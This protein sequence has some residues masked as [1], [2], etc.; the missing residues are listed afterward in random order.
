MNELDRF[1]SEKLSTAIENAQDTGRADLAD[2]LQLKAA[3]DAFRQAGVEQF[4]ETMIEIA[5]RTEHA[6]KQIAVERESPHSF[7]HRDANLVGSLVRLRY[8]VRCMTVEAGWTRTPSDGFM[9]LGALAF[10]RITH[11]GIPRANAE[12]ILKNT[13]GE[14]TWAVVRR[15]K[16]DT[17]FELV[18]L[19]EHFLV[20]IDERR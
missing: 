4:F 8:G 7:R 6:S 13:G 14:A 9:R 10:A 1:W 18:E 3:N 15:D 20:L 17:G 5:T 16:V 12:F 11:F 2:Y 19:N